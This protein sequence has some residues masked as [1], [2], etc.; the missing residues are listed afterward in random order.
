MP[1]GTI[2][3]VHRRGEPMRSHDSE[4]SD[5]PHTAPRVVE[6]DRENDRQVQRLLS[7][8]GSGGDSRRRPRVTLA[9]IHLKKMYNKSVLTWFLSLQRTPA[10]IVDDS[11]FNHSYHF[12][13][14]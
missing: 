1:R 10:Q 8:R 4:T 13:D 7:D 2:P 9:Y 12:P 14:L 5:R 3:R 11:L 6:Q